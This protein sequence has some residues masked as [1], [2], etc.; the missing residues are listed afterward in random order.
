MPNSMDELV[1]WL[2]MY[3]YFLKID[4]LGIV[5]GDRKTTA[6]I[7]RELIE[8]RKAYP[9]RMCPKCGNELARMMELHPKEALYTPS[10][11]KPGEAFL[12]CYQCGFNSKYDWKNV[13]VPWP[14]IELKKYTIKKEDDENV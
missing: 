13:E 4:P 3:E 1:E 12:E 9:S 8:I 14:K 6:N 2:S 11:N 10:E 5:D 7:I